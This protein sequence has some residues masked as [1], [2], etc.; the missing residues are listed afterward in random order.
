M[1][2]AIGVFNGR[3]F[4]GSHITDY[5]ASDA[6]KMKYHSDW[7]WLMPVFHAIR[8]KA[9]ALRNEKANQLLAKLNTQLLF[10]TI[11]DVHLHAFRFIEYV[12]KQSTTT[13]EAIT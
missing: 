4:S 11:A 6:P 12:N 7:N 8:E 10:G 2:Y 1:N 5:E 13:N 3:S 9:F